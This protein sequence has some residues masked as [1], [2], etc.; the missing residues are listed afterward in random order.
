MLTRRAT[1]QLFATAP[2]AYAIATPAFAATDPVYQEGGIAVDGSDVVA[3]FT[4]GKPVA[5]TAA[6][7]VDWNGATWQFSS[8]EDAEAFQANPEAYAPQ[9]GGYCAWA[10]A[11]GYIAGT[12]RDAWTIHEGKLYLNFN[13]RIRRRWERDIPGNVTRG[14]A[15]WPAILA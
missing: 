15:N 3:Y 2:V 4:E 12:R 6:H 1:L 14:D 7:T 9:Y 13:K 11:E 5:G 8:A 10:A